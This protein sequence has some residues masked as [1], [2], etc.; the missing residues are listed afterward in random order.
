M[1]IELTKQEV[2][3]L[4][5]ALSMAHVKAKQGM[6]RAQ[7]NAQATVSGWA[8]E[9]ADYETLYNKLA[10]FVGGGK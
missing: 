7:S 8:M 1:N 10:Q 6:R 9:A 2:M 3:T 4:R 5:R